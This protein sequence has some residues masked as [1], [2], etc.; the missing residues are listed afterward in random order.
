[1]A[2]PKKKPSRK[3]DSKLQHYDLVICGGGLAGMTTAAILAGRNLK[4]ALVDRL[5]PEAM[6]DKRFD[7]RTTAI[8]FGSAQVLEQAGVWDKVAKEGAPIT[9]IDVQEG[10]APFILKFEAQEAE[11][12]A[13]GWIF[14]NRRLRLALMDR[15]RSLDNL[16]FLTPYEV[17]NYE[18]NPDQAILELR[19]SDGRIRRLTADLLIAA[20]GRNSIL[21][22]LADI[23]LI[24]H[25][26]GQK[27]LVGTVYHTNP[28]QGLA[29][30]RFMPDGPF[31]ILPLTD[32]A[33]GEHRSALVWT[34]EEN[35]PDFSRWPDDLFQ[36]ALKERFDNRYG[37]VR[38][39]GPKMTF[40]LSLYHAQQMTAE[41][42]LLLS[43]AAHAIHPI[44]GQG[45]NLGMQDI[46]LLS[47]LL[48]TESEHNQADF[49]RPGILAEYERT[50]RPA[51]FQMVA[52]T[53][54]LN[55]LFSNRIGSVKILRNIGLAAVE[56]IPLLKRFFMNVAMGRH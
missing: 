55:R 50:R 43:D 20:D 21:R 15:L 41:R 49:G 33:K 12:D 52:A 11:T 51:V 56:R 24:R 8:S 13:F 22:T 5:T 45:L 32:S 4:I 35:G 14:S 7:T 39:Q 40:P 3:S 48:K 9:T 46:A 19:Q 37:E 16:T 47:R 6:L 23:P 34:M 27:A 38:W 31:A 44:A 42:L 10:H 26:Y 53:D 28:H 30:E 36:Q 54:L 29:V 1:M 25:Q 17:W 2:T 18:A